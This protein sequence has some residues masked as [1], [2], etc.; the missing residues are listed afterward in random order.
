MRERESVGYLKNRENI[1]LEIR[2]SPKFSSFN[3]SF[4]YIRDKVILSKKN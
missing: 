2:M 4:F 3:H 1:H